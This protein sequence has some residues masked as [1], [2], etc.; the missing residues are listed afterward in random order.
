MADIKEIIDIYAQIH[1]FH[2]DYKPIIN[3]MPSSL[4]KRAFDQLLNMKRNP[5][6][7]EEISEKNTGM[8]I[9]NSSFSDKAIQTESI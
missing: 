2:P 8:Q 9:E 6:S 7:L 5:I 4:V 3:K 1:P